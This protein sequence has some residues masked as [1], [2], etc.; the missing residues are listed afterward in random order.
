MKYRGIIEIEKIPHL[1]VNSTLSQII[2]G[3]WA[4]EPSAARAYLPHVSR[5]LKGERLHLPSEDTHHE[6]PS[7]KSEVQGISVFRRSRSSQ[8]FNDAP[9]NSV[10]VIPITGP[11]MK[12]GECGEPGTNAWAQWVRDA[13]Q[14]PNISSIVLSIDS[15]GGAVGG[16]ATL[17]DAVKATSKKVTAFVDDGMAASAAYWIASAA[18]EIVLS[19]PTSEVGSIGVFVSLAD[20]K[21]WF[22]AN[23][24]RIVDIYSSYS[25]EKNKEVEDALKGDTS[26]MINEHLDPIANRFI[27][28][29]KKNRAG[30][31]NLSAGDPF[32]GKLY[33]AEKAIEIGLADRVASFVEVITGL[34]DTTFGREAGKSNHQN[35][36]E[37]AKEWPAVAATLEVDGIEMNEQGVYLTEEQMNTINEGL[38][39][40]VVD[41]T[42]LEE[43]EA[44]VTTLEDNAAAALQVVNEQLQVLGADPVEDVQVGITRIGELAVQYGQASG[45]V[46]S[47]AATDKHTEEEERNASEAEKINADLAAKAGIDPQKIY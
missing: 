26:S 45:D 20:W 39:R 19:H 43:A 42:R 41:A 27:G 8:S 7:A 16:T 5:M 11:I 2:N 14:S 38:G 37:M 46:S 1:K 30:Q 22:E 23:D 34:V 4:M 29:V 35:T 33:S 32:K 12:E 44:S 13:D 24:L 17:A 21:G 9:A 36:T 15:P 6:R 28:V 25:T 10:A 47:T 31:L 18:D 40:T 3:A